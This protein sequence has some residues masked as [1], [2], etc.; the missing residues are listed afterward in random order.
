M[1]STNIISLPEIKAHIF[2]LYVLIVYCFSFKNV[3]M[4]DAWVMMQ[5]NHSDN[6]CLVTKSDEIYGDVAQW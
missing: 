3:L 1:H 5:I 2:L 6:V 4:G